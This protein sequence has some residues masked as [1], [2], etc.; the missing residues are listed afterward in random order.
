MSS[1]VGPMTDGSFECFRRKVTSVNPAGSRR[2]YVILSCATSLDGYL[3]DATDDRLLLSNDEDFDRVDAV[4]AG[5]DAIVVGSNTI[6]RDNPRLVVRSPARRVARVARGA[7][8]TPVKVTITGRGDLDP[9]AQFFVT[10]E[11]DK[12]VYASSTALDPTRQRVGAVA[13]VIDGGN[14]IDLP[15]V[16]ADLDTRRIGALLVEGGAATHTQFLTA[17]LAD[18][19]Q[20]VIAP[21]FVGDPAAPRFVAGGVFPWNREHRAHLHEVRQIG[22]CVLLRYALS[23]R[24]A[25]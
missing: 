15:Y 12:L 16:L 3:D 10:G 14:P 17:G 5:V 6:R 11:T 22:D 23:D 1:P 7:S 4:R 18:E 19:L 9:T 2:P 20:L 21:L 25:G 8:A 13:S 24:F